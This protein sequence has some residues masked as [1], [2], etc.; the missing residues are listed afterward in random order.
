[1]RKAGATVIHALLFCSAASTTVAWS[2][3]HSDARELAQAIQ[4]QMVTTYSCQ[5]FLGGPGQYR[6]AKANAEYIY[7]RVTRDRNAAVLAVEKIDHRIRESGGDEQLDS[8]LKGLSEFDK[9]NFCLNSAAEDS[10]RVRLL[11][12][13]LHLL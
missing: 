10:D 2:D 1:M 6:A 5:K 8:A 12:A 13:R 9:T 11:E 4:K 7:T 3:E